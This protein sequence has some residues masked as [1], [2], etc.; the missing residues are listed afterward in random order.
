MNPVFER[1]EGGTR[2]NYLLGRMTSWMTVEPFIWFLMM[3]AA[4]VLFYQSYK[5]REAGPEDRF[6]RWAKRFLESA[7][8][9]LL[10]LGILWTCRNILNANYDTFR[11]NHGRVSE[12]NYGSVT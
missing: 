8:R 3:A 7:G 5:S 1:I 9:A 4:F 12:V 6:W 2:V 11:S 10:F